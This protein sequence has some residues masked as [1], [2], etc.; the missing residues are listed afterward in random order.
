MK[1]RHR[2]LPVLPNSHIPAKAVYYLC[3]KSKVLEQIVRNYLARANTRFQSIET[4]GMYAFKLG[5]V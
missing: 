3:V 1:L 2:K 5:Y 4:S